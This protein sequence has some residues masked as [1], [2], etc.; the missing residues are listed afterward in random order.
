MTLLLASLCDPISNFSIILTSPPRPGSCA[1]PKPWH[2]AG[3]LVA[4]TEAGSQHGFHV[5]M[6][7]SIL[8]VAQTLRLLRLLAA[9]RGTAV[10]TG[11]MPNTLKG[12]ENNNKSLAACILGFDSN[13]P[14]LK[15]QAKKSN[16]Y[17]LQCLLTL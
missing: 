11:A 16:L 3:L 10:A 17:R 12:K 7:R 8:R 4:T 13:M 5:F 14:K 1:C 15:H 6:L 2:S 9:T